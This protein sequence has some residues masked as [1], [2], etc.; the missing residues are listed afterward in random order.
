MDLQ[1]LIEFDQKLLL[2]LN[3]NDSVFWD[4]F[5][6]AVT[7]TITWIPL[8]VVLLYVLIKNTSWRDML[9]IVVMT[10]LCVI[11]ADQFASS[12]CKPYFERFR[13]T[14]DPLLMYQVDVVDN[15]RCGRY[16]FISSHAA[17][18]FSIF[19]F[20]SLLIR[21]RALTFTLLLNAMLCS[22]SRI[23]LGVHYPG[24]VLAGTLWGLLTGTI[25]YWIYRRLHRWICEQRSFISSQYTS[26]G[27]LVTDVQLLLSVSYLTL[28]FAAVYSCYL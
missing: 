23:Y 25:I 24:D 16:G 13:P 9:L 27:Y 22:Y 10:A 7:E 12:F 2:K 21:K 4:H 14:N 6:M 1:Q 28:F 19:A 20:N 5:M 18:H 17:N 8:V 3:M 26:T 11:V 15:Y